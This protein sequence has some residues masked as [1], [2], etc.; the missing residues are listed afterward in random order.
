LAVVSSPSGNLSHMDFGEEP[1]DFLIPDVIEPIV[2][3]RGWN[4]KGLQDSHVSPSVRVSSKLDIEI[5]EPGKDVVAVCANSLIPS[6][7]SRTQGKDCGECPSPDSRAHYGFGCGI[8]AYRDP[9]MAAMNNDPMHLRGR[10]WGEVLMWGNV[11]EHE[12]GFRAQ[13]AYPSAFAWTLGSRV[14]EVARALSKAYG[15]GLIHDARKVWER[16]QWNATTRVLE[17]GGNKI[18]SSHTADPIRDL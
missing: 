9:P 1:L 10:I 8:Y 6:I 16:G 18:D 17:P 4:V 13:Y 2:G 14:E 5:W 7:D 3:Y 12:Y 15:V 11:Y